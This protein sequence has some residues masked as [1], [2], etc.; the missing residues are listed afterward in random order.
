MLCQ[1]AYEYEAPNLCKSDTISGI[2]CT[3]DNSPVDCYFTWDCTCFNGGQEYGWVCIEEVENTPG[4]IGECR[5][6]K[7]GG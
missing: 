7:V 2:A 3:D 1:I 5:N 6:Y 4:T